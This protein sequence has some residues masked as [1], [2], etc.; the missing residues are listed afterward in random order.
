AV[1]GS[2]ND[3]YREQSYGAFHVEG[4]VFDWV[5]VGKKRAAYSEGSGTGNKSVL[6]GE[7]VDKL[8]AR[9]GKDTLKDFDDL[10]FLYA[11]DRVPTNRGALYYPHS[12]SFLSQGKR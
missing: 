9:D 8:L 3:Y 5:E 10:F 2:L 11:G 1:Y 7:A 12:G 6:L 4:K